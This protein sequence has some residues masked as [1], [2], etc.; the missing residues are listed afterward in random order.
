MHKIR[1]DLIDVLA[2][3]MQLPQ[4]LAGARFSRQSKCLDRGLEPE[5]RLVGEQG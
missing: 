5:E 4:R 2:Q 3:L 1:R